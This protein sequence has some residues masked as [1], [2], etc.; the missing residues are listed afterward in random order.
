MV[1]LDDALPDADAVLFPTDAGTALTAPELEYEAAVARL[2]LLGGPTPPRTITVPARPGDGKS[3]PD[4]EANPAHA[5]YRQAQA[6]AVVDREL[7]RAYEAFVDEHG[8]LYA[9]I[10]NRKAKHRSNEEASFVLHYERRRDEQP[11]DVQ[12]AVAHLDT[13]AAALSAA[14]EAHAA[15]IARHDEVTADQ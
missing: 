1:F 15:A 13:T 5:T 12:H 10:T 6:S 8:E 2:A 11:V 4:V 14:E 7:V 9:E 3:A